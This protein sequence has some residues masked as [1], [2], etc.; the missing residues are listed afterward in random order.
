[1]QSVYGSTRTT[2]VLLTI[3]LKPLKPGTYK[4]VW[5]VLSVDG[6]R[7]NGEY[8]FAVAQ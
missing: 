3:G 4:V 6:H 1:M 7:T 2:A 5:R 8:T